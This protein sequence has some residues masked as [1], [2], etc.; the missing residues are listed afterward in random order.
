MSDKS[1]VNTGK[2]DDAD[3]YV[4]VGK[5]DL[6]DAKASVQLIEKEWAKTN[7]EG[8]HCSSVQQFERVSASVVAL[9]IVLCSG[10]QCQMKMAQVDLNSRTVVF[11]R[12]TKPNFS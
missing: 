5:N 9:K 10:E 12:K 3:L 1:K 7:G 6:E 11:P 4:G 8:W 2:H